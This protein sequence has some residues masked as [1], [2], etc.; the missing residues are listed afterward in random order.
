MGA[1][2]LSQHEDP[3]QKN[4][5]NEKGLE[6]L[7]AGLAEVLVG[8]IV[9]KKLNQSRNCSRGLAVSR[10]P[11]NQG[12]LHRRSKC[13]DY[14]TGCANNVTKANTNAIKPNSALCPTLSDMTIAMRHCA[15]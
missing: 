6:K 14:P 13:R 7:Q 8:H 15:K 9:H 4:E 2:K 11:N 10:M 12:T 1:P 5:N 3:E